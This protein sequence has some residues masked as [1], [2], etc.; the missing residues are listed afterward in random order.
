L[1]YMHIYIKGQAIGYLSYP[2]S[3]PQPQG[4]INNNRVNCHNKITERFK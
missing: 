1:A 3:H 2:G 4:P